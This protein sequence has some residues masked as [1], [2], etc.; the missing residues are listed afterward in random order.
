MYNTSII[1]CNAI[2]SYNSISSDLWM[3]VRAM[4]RAPPLVIYIGGQVV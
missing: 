4:A 1:M 3:H 2:P